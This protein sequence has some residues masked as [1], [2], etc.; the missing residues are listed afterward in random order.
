[1][2]TLSQPLVSVVTPVYNGAKYLVDCIESVLSQSYDNWEYIIIDN[3]SNDQT[4][5]IAQRYAERDGRI[6][7]QRND[8]VLPII[9]N[10]NHALRQIS[11][12][13]MYCK[14][15]CADDWLFPECLE[16]MVGLAESRP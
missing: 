8:K 3:C 11:P 7:V 2:R 1:M 15:V 12:M 13:S 6:R 9:A 10:F 5:A 14:V 16:R 4:G